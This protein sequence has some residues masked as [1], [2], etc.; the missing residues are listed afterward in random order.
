MVLSAIFEEL[1]GLCAVEVEEVVHCRAVE[2]GIKSSH[3]SRG[4]T[5]KRRVAQG[6]PPGPGFGGEVSQGIEG[7]PTV[8]GQLAAGHRDH[9]AWSD[10]E[11]V[12]PARVERRFLSPWQDVQACESGHHAFVTEHLRP[13][14][15]ICRIQEGGDVGGLRGHATGV[16]A[17]LFVVVPR[18]IMPSH[19]TA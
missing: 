2:K 16:P 15:V 18:R 13:Q 9:T 11:E 5:W 17:V 19:G 6:K 12:I 4:G 10:A 1:A 3:A 7:Y 8:R 14:E